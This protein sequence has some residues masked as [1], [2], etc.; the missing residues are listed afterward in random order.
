MKKTLGYVTGFNASL[1]DSPFFSLDLELSA[2]RQLDG[3]LAKSAAGSSRATITLTASYAQP[4]RLRVTAAPPPGYEADVDENYM[5]GDAMRVNGRKG[6]SCGVDI[7]VRFGVPIFRKL[8]N[9]AIGQARTF[10]R[11]R[12][13]SR[14]RDI[15]E[16]IPDTR[17]AA[18]TDLKLAAASAAAIAG[19]LPPEDFSDWES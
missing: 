9:A 11:M 12:V 14:A 15:A 17:L 5:R 13:P 16:L 1:G 6:N 7:S 3:L 4:T 2:A 18:Q 8:L 19:V 10:V